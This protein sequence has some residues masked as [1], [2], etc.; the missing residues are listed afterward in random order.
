MAGR[1]ARSEFRAGSYRVNTK[2]ES[3]FFATISAAMAGPTVDTA[4]YSFMCYNGPAVE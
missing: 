1:I 2:P 4:S 3:R